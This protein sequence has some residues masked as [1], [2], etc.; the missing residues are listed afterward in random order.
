[1]ID[2]FQADPVLKQISKRIPRQENKQFPP[3][4]S[5]YMLLLLAGIVVIVIEDF[6]F[7][8]AR[9]FYTNKS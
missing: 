3:L 8:I 6:F 9:A 5:I 1:M 7:P 2:I 4:K